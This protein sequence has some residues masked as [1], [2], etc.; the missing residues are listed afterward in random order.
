MNGIM[1]RILS[2]AVLGALFGC[3]EKGEEKP[4]SGPKVA[5]IVFQEDQ[6]FRLVQFGMR[7]EA[8]K[9]GV[10][11]FEANSY[12]KPDKEVQLINTYIA[13]KVDAIVIAPLSKKASSTALKKAK[14]KGIKIITYNSDVDAGISSAYIESSQRD[15]GAQSGKEAR[16]YIEEKLGGKAKVAVLAFQSQVPEQSNAR[17]Q[18]FI[19][20]VKKLPGVEIIAEQDA[21]LPEMAIKKAGD[22]LTANP[23]LD[24]IWA[25]NEGGTVGAVMAVKNAG[26][27]GKVAVFGTDTSKQLVSFLTSKDGILQAITGQKPYVIGGKAL[28]AALGALGKGAALESVTTIPGQLLSR[29]RPDEAKAFLKR[30]KRLQS[31]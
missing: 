15:L 8:E 9:N 7:A 30:L 2:L 1:S 21:W 25:A 13:K 17:S 3:V 27:A 23:D 4:S 19:Q 26:K 14:A 22:I 10:S 6:F 5:G 11:L 12:N 16:K 18:G 31:H 24:I 20:E 29:S 28:S